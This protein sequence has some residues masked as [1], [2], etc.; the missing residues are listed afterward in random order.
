MP[1]MYPETD[2]PL[3]PVTPSRLDALRH[4]IPEPWDKIVSKFAK[5]FDLPSQLAEPLFDS[6][7]RDL[8]EKIV[9]TTKLAPRYVASVLI[10]IF[11]SLAREGVPV[12]SL[13]LDIIADLFRSLNEGKFA[14]EAMPDVLR[15]L[16]AEPLLDVQGALSKAGISTM[17]IEETA[18]A[19]RSTSSRKLRTA[20]DKREGSSPKSA[21]G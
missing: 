16:A 6:D 10:D 8:F 11:Q 20:E 18:I 9:A 21:D 5:K 13:K 4:Q 14:K 12:Y 2:I 17:N 3:I 15:T 1:G 19:C 7:Y